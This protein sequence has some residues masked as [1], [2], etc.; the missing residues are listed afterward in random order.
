M[1]L[2]ILRQSRSCEAT[3]SRDVCRSRS[4]SPA[5]RWPGVGVA[6]V[7]VGVVAAGV[8]VGMVACV[9]VGMVAGVGVAGLVVAVARAELP[10]V[11]IER[12]SGGGFKVG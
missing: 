10:D 4:S 12:I 9:D 3:D 5:Y 8:D 11:D 2:S 6:G 7:G 1:R